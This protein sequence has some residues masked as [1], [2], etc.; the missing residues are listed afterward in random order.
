MKMVRF[1]SLKPLIISISILFLS[2][3]TAVVNATEPCGDFGE[4]KALIEINA[5]DGDIGFHFLMDGDDINAAM[6]R[7]P[8]G[9]KVF[10]D[11]A[12]GPLLEQKL[13]EL[14]A[15]SAEP[16]CWADPEADPDEEIVTLEE[17]LERWAPGSYR[18]TAKGDQGERLAGE[19]ELTYS[20]PAA[21]ADV[22]FD[23]SFIISWSDGDDLGNC[24]SENVLE[25]L[26]ED[27]ILPVHPK[28]VYVAAWEVVLEPDVEDGEPVSALKYTIRLPGD[29][30]PKEVTVPADY[31]ASLPK[32]TPVKVEVGAIGEDDNATFTEEDGFCV[33]EDE[34]CE[35]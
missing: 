27:G 24:A 34:G 14:F 32:D 15:E 9:A 5:S 10:Q 7:D 35:D 16:L 19:T 13:T 4:C 6:L 28:D 2:T 3:E 22:N 1:V 25:I 21:P 17:F 20:L 26:V 29:I 33:N 18:F 31:L 11:Q 23:G 30:D 12:K 8:N